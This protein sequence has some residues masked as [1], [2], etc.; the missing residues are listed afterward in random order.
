MNLTP[1]WS[2]LLLVILFAVFSFMKKFISVKTGRVICPI[3]FATTSTWM[4][5]GL[6]HFFPRVNFFNLPN[7]LLFMAILM[8]GSVVGLVDLLGKSPLTKD[9]I[10]PVSKGIL[11]IFLFGLDYIAL[12]LNST[13]FFV[14]IVGIWGIGLFFMEEIPKE[15]VKEVRSKNPGEKEKTD[16][17]LEEY[18]KN[19]C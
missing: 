12:N 7:N 9:L 5:M 15:L 11:L 2:F 18:L 14:I 3:C 8:G 1:L 6:L 19:C 10:N 4:T 17:D 16:K 13:V